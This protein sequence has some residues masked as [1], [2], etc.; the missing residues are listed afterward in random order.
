M[1]DS[2]GDQSLV[3]EWLTSGLPAPLGYGSLFCLAVYEEEIGRRAKRAAAH[4]VAV[5]AAVDRYLGCIAAGH[6]HRHAG[7]AGAGLIRG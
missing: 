1:Q 4:A 3:N 5:T 6:G 7:D 2:G